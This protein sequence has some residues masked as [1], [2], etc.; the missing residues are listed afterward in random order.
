MGTD[1]GLRGVAGYFFKLGWLAFGG[2]VGQ[3]GLMHLE[4]VARKGWL[5]E[6]EFLRALNFCHLLP[7]PEATQLAIYIGWRRAGWIGG[8]VAGLLFI[9]PG[10]LTLSV[11]AWI[12][13]RFGADPRVMAVLWGFRPVGLALLLAAL[14]RIGRATLKDAETIALA[15]AA[16][17]A[18]TFTGAPF[19]LLLLGCGAAHLLLRR[20]PRA[21]AALALLALPGRADALEPAVRRLADVSWFFLKVGLFSFGGAYAVLPYLRAGSVTTY[22]WMTD[23]QM[24][25]ALALGETT[26][27][28]LISI[29]TFVG[30]LAGAGAGVPWWGAAAATFWL[31]L[32]S[33][34]LV[35]AAVGS[36][37]RLLARPGV[38]EFL[39]GVTCAVVGLMFSIAIP[40][41]RV[42][43]MPGGT[44][45]PVTVVLG[46][47]AFAV[48]TWWRYRLNV[49]AV[50]LGGG[51]AGL[52]RA[53][54]T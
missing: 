4:V 53:L 51:A 22:G 7:G 12:Y 34:V 36:M 16:F 47:A 19:P 46:L 54:V 42:A 15:L 38:K 31:F 39:K 10:F 41:A 18:F 14:V 8:V 33:F 21:A 40:L 35:L 17:A 5:D 1:S 49:V 2:P 20:S 25:D 28:P 30:F 11:L 27:G 13:V 50:V 48:L 43:V 6:E 29:G 23:H 44:L 37:D 52:L 24:I 3:I 9:L 32:P 45:D 26:P